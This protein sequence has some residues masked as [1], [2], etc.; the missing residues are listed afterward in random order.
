MKTTINNNM[1][2]YQVI[3]S[4]GKQAFCNIN[5]LNKV[6]KELGTRAGYFS[7]YHFW[8]NK[9]KKV[10]KTDLK[11]FFEGSQLKQNFEY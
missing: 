4:T 11:R 6:V 5:Q 10:S 1:R 9:A 7:I 8:D 2:V 3:T